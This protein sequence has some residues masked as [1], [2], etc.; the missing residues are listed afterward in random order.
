M[1]YINLKT[2]IEVT[3]KAK[4]MTALGELISILPGKTVARTMVSVEDKVALCFAGSDEPCAII[5]TIVNPESIMD[6]NKEKINAIRQIR[7][8]LF[9]L[10]INFFIAIIKKTSSK[11]LIL[12]RYMVRH[13]KTNNIRDLICS[14]YL[15]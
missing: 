3:D 15:Q 10:M 11:D 6:N 1:P 2:N 9:S 12:P 8:S 7:Q 5:E 14:H 4:I 13:G